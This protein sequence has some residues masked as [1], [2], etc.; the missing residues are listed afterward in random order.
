MKLTPLGGGAYHLRAV[1]ENRGFLPTHGSNQAKKMKA[2]RPVRLEL[3]L[4]VGATL[5]GGKL[6]QEIGQLEGRSNKLSSSHDA[7]PTDNRGKAEWVVRAPA[8]A[9]LK[10]RVIAERAGT[11]AR[12]ITLGA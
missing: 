7:S 9:A 11:L 2:V 5:A 12:E 8:G 6:R 3:A 1:I 10:L 4:P